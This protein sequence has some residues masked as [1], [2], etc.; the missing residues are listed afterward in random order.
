[1]RDLKKV[2]NTRIYLLPI[3]Q[4]ITVFLDNIKEYISDNYMQ[5][6]E[7]TLYDLITYANKNYANIL[8]EY[9]QL[10]GKNS[11]QSGYYVDYDLK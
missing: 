5:D 9:Q 6:F 1:V 2:Q 8:A 10:S 7:E 3:D 4:V 11:S